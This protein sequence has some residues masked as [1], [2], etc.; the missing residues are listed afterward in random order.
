MVM[1]DLV[2]RSKKYSS[3]DIIS[4]TFDSSDVLIKQLIVAHF[5]H[6]IRENSAEDAKFVQQRAAD[7]GLGY[8]CH[9]AKLGA[10]CSEETAR[11]ARYQF[12]N[13]V[14]AEYDQA[15]IYTAHHLNDLAES[16]AINLL[17]GTGW[18]GLTPL[19]TLGLRRPLLD[20][21]LLQR[22]GYN[23]RQPLTKK[24]IWR[25]AA[26]HRLRFREDQTN[27]SDEYLRNRLRHQMNNFEKH[28]QLFE[29][30]ERQK[31]L[32]QEIDDIIAAML[33]D[34]GQVWPRG[35]FR[36]LESE[37]ALELLRAGLA[38]IGGSATRPQLERFRQA[39]LDYAPGK[40]FNLPNDQLVRIN[41]DFFILK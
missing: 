15:E 26:E 1:L 36:D 7:Y 31:G 6:G 18:R 5:D 21:S 17:R 16:I 28:E 8:V 34:S 24:A 37:V 27:S 35:W 30:W 11:K 13:Q 29:L 3:G 10:R 33:P 32:R 2:A 40:Y 38:E 19:A 12:L 22:L 41:K 25:Y 20:P 23:L 39:I 9:R 14:S 4:Q